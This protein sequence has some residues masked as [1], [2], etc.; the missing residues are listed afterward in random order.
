MAERKLSLHALRAR[1]PNYEMVKARFDLNEK[2]DLGAIF[3]HLKTKYRREK[4]NTE[5][6]LRID[7]DNGWIHLRP[8][9]TEPIIRLYAESRHETIAQNLTEKIMQDIRDMRP[10]TQ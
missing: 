8:S 2:L 6:G 7:F 3:E 1:Y 5:D 4:I 9:N 10:Q